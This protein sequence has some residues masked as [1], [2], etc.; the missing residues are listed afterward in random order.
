MASKF[1][2]VVKGPGTLLKE[3]TKESKDVF[4]S[5][6][7]EFEED[8]SN[9]TFFD[10]QK[11]WRPKFDEKLKDIKTLQLENDDGVIFVTDNINGD[12]GAIH[13]EPKMDKS[14]MFISI[15]PGTK[16]D[17]DTLKEKKRGQCISQQSGGYYDKL[18]KYRKKIEKL[19]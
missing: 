9:E 10:K 17:I 11:R 13:S 2:T 15:A 3:D 7:K 8:K 5:I 16:E 12:L 1:V 18:N 6:W 4:D 19:I 14:R